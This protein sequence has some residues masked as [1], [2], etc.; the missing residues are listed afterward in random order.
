MELIAAATIWGL[1]SCFLLFPLSGLPAAEREQIL[2]EWSAGP[3][4]EGPERCLHELV[5]E[6]A[7]KIPEAPIHTGRITRPLVSRAC[8]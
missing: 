2:H 8:S 6:Q 3:V 5:F 1:F 7:E 4:P